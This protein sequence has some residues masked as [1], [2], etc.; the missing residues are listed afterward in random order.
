M[1]MSR[2]NRF[3]QAYLEAADFADTPEDHTGEG[4]NF[5]AESIAMTEKDCKAFLDSA[6]NLIG[7]KMEQAGHDFWLTR[8]GHGAGFWDRPEIY[9]KEN[10]RRLTEI[11]KRFSEEIYVGVKGRHENRRLYFY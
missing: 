2:F 6:W 11:S 8:R 10:A 1:K 3:V 5:D 7:D 9:G 4:L